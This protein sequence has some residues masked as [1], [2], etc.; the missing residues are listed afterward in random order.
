MAK[1]ILRPTGGPD[2]WKEFLAE[3]KHWKVGYSAHCLACSWEGSDGIPDAVR[4]VFAVS[5]RFHALEPLLAIPEVKVDLPGGTRPSQTDLWLLAR[6]ADGL[7]SVAVE[8][9]VEESFGP[10]VDEWQDNAASG[11]AQRLAFLLNLLRLKSA[12]TLRYQLLHRTASAILLARRFHATHAIMIVHSFSDSDAGFADYD[13]FVKA[14]GAVGAV[15]QMVAI[16]GHSNPALAV[17]WV[18]DKKPSA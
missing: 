5:D 17:G 6:V 14:L 2:D 1:L 11:K 12:A 4:A 9:K 15:N 16:P 7:V 8:G 13:A 18:K 3:P 10:S